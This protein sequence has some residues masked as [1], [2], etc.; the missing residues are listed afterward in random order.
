MNIVT[1][2]RVI[3]IYSPVPHCGKSTLASLLR[4]RTPDSV[5]IIPFAGPLKKFAQDFLVQIAGLSAERAVH[6]LFTDK[7]EPI[8]AL[9]G[10]TGRVVLQRI[11]GCGRQIDPDIWVRKWHRCASA[12]LA[13][14]TSVIADDVRA[15]NEATAVKNL[16]GEMWHLS[17]ASAEAEADPD[18][19]ADV[20]EG[21]LADWPFDRSFH[22]DWTTD[23]L[24]E[25]AMHDL[26][27]FPP[28]CQG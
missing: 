11:G 1:L 12:A 13:V 23:E 15:R 22:N 19:T 18:V 9:G 25:A 21:A 10:A 4:D 8:H 17:R 14:G 5:R 28:T 26:H 6:H 2:P 16:G 20:S 3:G 24:I 7:N 27:T